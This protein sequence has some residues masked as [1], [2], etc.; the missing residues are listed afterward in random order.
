MDSNSDDDDNDN[1]GDM[2]VMVIRVLYNN[3]YYYSV[4]KAFCAIVCVIDFGMF[5]VVFH[6]RFFEKEEGSV[7]KQDCFSE[8]K[9]KPCS[10]VLPSVILK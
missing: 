6:T 7:S 4:N 2:M 10:L 8:Y 5:D 1:G 9:I 3:Y